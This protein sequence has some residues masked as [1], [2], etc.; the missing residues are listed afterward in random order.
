MV[1]L[2][3]FDY[4]YLLRE[5][6]GVKFNMNMAYAVNEVAQLKKGL[7]PLNRLLEKLYR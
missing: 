6:Q 4:W 3:D 7:L 5:L 1:S 2:M